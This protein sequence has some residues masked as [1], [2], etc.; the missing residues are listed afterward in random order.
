MRI[1]TDNPAFEVVI[2]GDVGPGFAKK[3]DLGP[4][5]RTTIFFLMLLNEYYRSFQN[6]YFHIFGVRRSIDV[7]DSENQPDPNPGL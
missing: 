1:Q 4:V 7:L 6:F 3:P 5:P 2:L